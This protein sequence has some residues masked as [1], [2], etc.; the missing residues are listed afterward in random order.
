MKSLWKQ[1]GTVATNIGGLAAAV[2]LL[3]RTGATV[4]SIGHRKNK[5]AKTTETV[6]PPNVTDGGQ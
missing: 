5:S 1:T 2:F 4:T 6:A 3:H